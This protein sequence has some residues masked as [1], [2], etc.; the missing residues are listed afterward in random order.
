MKSKITMIINATMVVFYLS[1]MMA[2]AQNPWEVD[3][4]GS[5]GNKWGQTN[6]TAPNNVQSIGIGDFIGNTTHPISA[7][8][9]NTNWLPTNGAFGLGEVFRTQAPD[10]VTQ[11]WRMLYGTGAGTEVFNINNVNAADAV[12][13]GTVQDGDLKFFINSTDRMTLRTT[14][15]LDILTPAS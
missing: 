15:N 12:S 4:D 8:H 14:G 5:T 11:A 2:K 6:T 10:N 7:L 3:N 1:T 13:L 9:I